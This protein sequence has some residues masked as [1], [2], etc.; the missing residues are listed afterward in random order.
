MENK[1]QDDKYIFLL[2]LYQASAKKFINISTTS[3]SL[4]VDIY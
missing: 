2:N 4:K 3:S 1:S